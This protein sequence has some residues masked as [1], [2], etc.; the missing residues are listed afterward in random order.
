MHFSEE[1]NNSISRHRQI[2]YSIVS[3][4]PSGIGDSEL[5]NEYLKI[6]QYI[7]FKNKI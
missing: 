3:G 6:L 4:Y 5:K 1:S 2:V 7:F